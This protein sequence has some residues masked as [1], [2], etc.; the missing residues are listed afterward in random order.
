MSTSNTKLVLLTGG[1]GFIGFQTLLDAL[2][3]GF[4]VRCTVRSEAKGEALLSK[5]ALQPFLQADNQA[6]SVEIVVVPDQAARKAFHEA[7]KGTSYVIHIASP[8]PSAVTQANGHLDA[9]ANFLAP[10]RRT[11]VEMLEAAATTTSVERVVMTSSVAAFVSPK[12]FMGLMRQ[13]SQHPF[14]PTSRM[15]LM[16]PPFPHSGVA[17]VASKV[18]S[19]AA[20]EA[21]VKET[22]PRFSVINIHPSWV[23]GRAECAEDV[24]S[25]FNTTNRLV[26]NTIVKGQ[27]SQYPV[28]MGA[29]VDVH[30]VA[31]MQVQ[32]LQKA[33]IVQP[34]NCRSFIASTPGIYEDI[35]GIIRKS[36][37][38]QC[39]D[40]RVTILGEQASF[41]LP[42]DSSSTEITFGWK[43]KTLEEMINDLIS[44]YIELQ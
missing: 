26:L 6:P 39:Q 24:G 31:R 16:T 12:I 32:S 22:N 37:A 25:L 13:D 23:M 40:G 8:L 10:A 30:D 4:R 7:I 18:E 43:F 15:P 29:V 42:I 38:E 19:L 21:W 3:A 14:T 5:P 9:E 28:M 44:Q 17:Y 27:K 20:T 1:T 41:P 33:D 35:P 34:G 11:A 36:F 2:R